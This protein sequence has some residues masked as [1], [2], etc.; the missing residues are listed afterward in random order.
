MSD[1]NQKNNNEKPESYDFELQYNLAFKDNDKDLSTQMK[2]KSNA[3]PVDNAKVSHDSTHAKKHV[4]SKNQDRGSREKSLEEMQR[5]AERAE[6]RRAEKK[7]RESGVAPI[8]SNTKSAST[9]ETSE[10]PHAV[11]NLNARPNTTKNNA[12]HNATRA[13]KKKSHKGLVI[14][15]LAAVAVIALIIF[16][17]NAIAGFMGNAKEIPTVYMKDN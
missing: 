17:V 13:N 1:K 8:K 10:N 5:A 11:R 2:A 7:R 4:T 15:S 12:A 9:V 3:V 16:G 6:R 14:G